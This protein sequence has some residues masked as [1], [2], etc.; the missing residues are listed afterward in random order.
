MIDSLI[1]FLSSFQRPVFLFSSLAI[2]VSLIL[3]RED[4]VL[5]AD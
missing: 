4:P 2:L 3:D 5:L 1:D